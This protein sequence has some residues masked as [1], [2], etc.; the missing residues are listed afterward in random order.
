MYKIIMRW[1]S[2]FLPCLTIL[3]M[4]ATC[5]C[6]SS[7]Q[8]ITDVAGDYSDDLQALKYSFDSLSVRL[9]QTSKEISSKMSKLNVENKTIIYSLPDSAGKQFPVKESTT[10]INRED[11]ERKETYTQMLSRIDKL[12]TE[13]NEFKEKVNTS[14]AAKETTERLSWWDKYKV[15][16]YFIGTIF[17]LI[18]IAKLVYKLKNRR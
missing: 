18:A 2:R 13:V 9:E 6:K 10:I 17:I 14:L 12:I 5:S 16:I 8:T 4:L 11:K 7:Q 1:I 3:L 15:K